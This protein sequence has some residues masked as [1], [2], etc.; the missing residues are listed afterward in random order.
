M[1]EE[2]RQAAFEEMWQASELLRVGSDYNDVLS[3][4]EANETVGEFVRGKIR[5][6]VDDPETAEAL[7]PTT[8]YI[9]TKR[10]CLDTNYYETYNLPHVRLVDLRQARRSTR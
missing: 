8:H 3:N 10:T 6:I 9:L 7:C 5:S 1:S 4:P 2:E